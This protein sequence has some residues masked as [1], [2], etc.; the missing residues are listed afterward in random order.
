MLLRKYRLVYELFN[1]HKYCT[2]WE[3]RVPNVG[4]DGTIV[5]QGAI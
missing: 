2:V 4:T 5:I 1:T 3:S